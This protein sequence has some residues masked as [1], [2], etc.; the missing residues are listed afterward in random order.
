MAVTAKQYA[1]LHSQSSLKEASGHTIKAALFTSALAPSQS[2]DALFTAAPYTANQV[3]SGTGYTTGGVAL[4]GVTLAT[5]AP[6]T[7]LD[8]ADPTITATGAGFTYRFVV[9]YDSTTN[10][11]ISYADMGADVV[12]P[13]G[14]HTITLDPLGIARVTVS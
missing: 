6:I 14:T 12:V 2:A 5:A 10:V 1:K 11:L 3:A 7:T 13:A 8:A 4:T 9:F